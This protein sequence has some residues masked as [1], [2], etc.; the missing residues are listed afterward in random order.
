MWPDV[1]SVAGEELCRPH[2]IEEYER[3]DHLSP[4]GR[5][6]AANLETAKITSPRDDH[7]LDGIAR[8][9]IAGYGIIV[10]QPAHW[11]TPVPSRGASLRHEARSL[12]RTWPPT[13]IATAEP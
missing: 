12:C 9:G 5:Q 3:P 10:G 2:L 8:P 7:I 4:C 6:G 13:R 11:C 1:D